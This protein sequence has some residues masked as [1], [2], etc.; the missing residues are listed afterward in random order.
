M[1]VN[2]STAQ[3]GGEVAYVVT[4]SNR[5]A[6]AF[7]Q[8]EVDVVFPLLKMDV[9]EA[10]DGT[11]ANDRV[12]WV[13]SELTPG[14]SQTFAFRA[15]FRP[16]LKDGDTVR[17]L[18][19]FRAQNLA[20]PLT[21]QSE[22]DIGAALSSGSGSTASRAAFFL[23]IGEEESSSSSVSAGT[24]FTITQVADQTE[25]QAG[26]RIRY[27]VTVRNASSTLSRATVTVTY[28]VELMR[29]LTAANGGVV[30]EG[31]ITWVMP[32]AAERTF[33]YDVRLASTLKEGETVVTVAEVATDRL[34]RVAT[35]EVHVI[36]SLPLTGSESRFYAPL[37]TG[38]FLH[39]Y[40]P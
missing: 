3:P 33:A 35:T 24:G 37:E 40:V 2:S 25:R 17:V 16:T 5:T 4:L 20:E 23:G 14:Q 9:T 29:V 11:V 32:T 28:P 18:A 19:S 1:T 36:G 26:A 27:T 8:G 6:A 38:K 12:T 34:Q 15:S 31:K 39:P 30:K 7:R 10:G 21:A 22:V 13:V